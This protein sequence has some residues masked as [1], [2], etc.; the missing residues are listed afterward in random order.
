MRV[1]K[2]IKQALRPKTSLSVKLTGYFV[3]FG[4]IIGYTVF[5]LSTA[6]SG[7]NLLENFSGSALS[8]IDFENMDLSN[9]DESEFHKKLEEVVQAV[10]TDNIPISE[11]TAY[12]NT[13]GSW[14]QR[15]LLGQNNDIH[16]PENN[17][18]IA[19]AVQ[20]GIAFSGNPFWG[21]AD[22]SRIYFHV[23]TDN[24]HTVVVS[25]A[26]TRIGFTELLHGKKT[27][28]IGFGIILILG[29]F[30]LGKIFAMSVTRPLR[31]L[32]EKALRISEGDTSISL[33]MRRRD[34]IGV[35]SRTMGQMNSDLSERLKAMEI[36]NRIDK[37][38][39]SS[40]SRNDL[41][42]RVIGF[43]CDYIDKSTA[44][45]ALRDDR[46]G[47]F[48]LI[49]A[50]KQ[51]EPAIL[52]ENPYIPDELLTAETQK[53]FKTSSVF[54]EDRNL[55]EVLIKQLNL[56]KNT[57]RFYNVALYLQERYLG[58]LL[59]IK[60]DQMPFTEE[61]QNT[62]RKLG[63]QVGV[64][65]QSVMAVEEVNSL[66]I[67][68]IQALSRS[69]DAKS[70][71][72][73]GHSE[74]VAELSEM[75]GAS[76]GMEELQL[77]RLV[78]SALLHD[79]GKIGISESILDKPGKLTDE[80]FTIIKQHPE[81]GYEISRNI[82]NYEDICDG[83]RYHH[84]RWNGS[85]YPIGIGENEIPRFGRI[86]AIA[87]VFDALSADRPYRAGLSLSD[88]YQFLDDKKGIDFDSE[89]VEVFL[90]VMKSS[91]NY[92]NNPRSGFKL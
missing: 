15:S 49:S 87:D 24:S 42:N 35:L 91:N 47:G 18:L 59:I 65:M 52:I 61:Q 85:G 21:K 25:A 38:V 48:E 89:L 44:V 2:H 41:L 14:M 74:R 34:E 71:W 17:P 83:I 32:T 5:I 58:S 80:E 82:P 70:R 13:G 51:S 22:T 68:S 79:I 69:I 11:I 90:D 57:K 10:Q 62:L 6:Y 86:I 81:L 31:R 26:I 4:L 20:K 56:P 36:M 84:E 66:Q 43:V 33:P 37:A 8:H 19:R 27:E 88:C 50:V 76:I 54:S 16:R 3:L 55:T 67:G 7:K 23:P 53:A 77:R 75:L 64:A 30:I 29:S 73:A 60:D 45:M 72:T 28:L 40:I 12:I 78:I 92:L 9:F 63:D 39:L 1:D 46:G